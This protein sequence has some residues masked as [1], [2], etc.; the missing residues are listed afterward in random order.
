[1]IA[2]FVARAARVAS[3]DAGRVAERAHRIARYVENATAT[4]LA[5]VSATSPMK[6]AKASHAN[7]NGHDDQDEHTDRLAQLPLRA[8]IDQG[9][10]VGMHGGDA[11]FG[12]RHRC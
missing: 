10:L 6:I 2:T 12:A 3:D 11:T 1:M 5:A 7:P 8:R 9:R 4:T